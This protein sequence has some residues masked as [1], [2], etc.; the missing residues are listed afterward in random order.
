MIRAVGSNERY[1]TLRLERMLKCAEQGHVRAGNVCIRCLEVV[2][3]PERGE[4][5]PDADD[6][7]AVRAPESPGASA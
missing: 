7:P 1:S 6:L 4:S 3:V 5:R 2:D